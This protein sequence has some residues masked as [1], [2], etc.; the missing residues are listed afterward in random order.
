M[1]GPAIE[2]LQKSSQTNADRIRSLDV[3]L[4]ARAAEL[5]EL[6]ERQAADVAERRKLQIE[7]DAYR[8]LLRELDATARYRR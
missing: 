5:K 4:D 2:L 6:S 7:L 3:D 8:A 1:I